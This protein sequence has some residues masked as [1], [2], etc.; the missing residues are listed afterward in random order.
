[1]FID[2]GT[3]VKDNI[4]ALHSRPHAGAACATFGQQLRIA[5]YR[6]DFPS[7][8]ACSQS[9]R[10]IWLAES[11]KQILCAYPENWTFPEVEILCTDKSSATSGDKNVC[12]EGLRISV[13]PWWREISKQSCFTKKA[14]NVMHVKSVFTMSGP[15]DYHV[16]FPHKPMSPFLIPICWISRIL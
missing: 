10:T 9:S 2:A 8:C 1:M 15:V 14:Y 4:C 12:P 11:T 16:M 13:L 7:L 5:T 6:N 3:K